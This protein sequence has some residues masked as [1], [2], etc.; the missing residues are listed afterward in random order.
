M[1]ADRELLQV[2]FDSFDPYVGTCVSDSA[3]DFQ[4]FERGGSF[5]LFECLNASF[6]LSVV[7]G[8][9]FGVFATS[10]WWIELN[11][12]GYCIWGSHTIPKNVQHIKLFVMPVRFLLIMFWPLLTIAPICSWSMVKK[13]NILFW[14]TIAGLVD[15][16]CCIACSSTRTIASLH[17]DR[18]IGTLHHDCE[19]WLKRCPLDNL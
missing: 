16:I 6:Q 8:I 3:E 18:R 15:V 13:S 10:L 5:S 7:C 12:N 1:S 11:V 4:A 9:L 2:S 17:N 14:C 19:K